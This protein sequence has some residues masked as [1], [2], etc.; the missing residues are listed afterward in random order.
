MTVIFFIEFIVSICAAFIGGALFDG[1][2]RYFRD[3][4][5]WMTGEWRQTIPA[6]GDRPKREDKVI[7]LNF[8]KGVTAKIIKKSSPERI[9]QNSGPLTAQCGRMDL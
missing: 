1:I 8:R 6:V 4:R 9:P 7:Y 3:R 5:G 2:V